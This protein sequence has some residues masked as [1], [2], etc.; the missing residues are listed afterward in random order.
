MCV[1]V[2]DRGRKEKYRETK[3]ERFMWGEGRNTSHRLVRASLQLINRFSLVGL[4]EIWNF[5]ERQE[6]PSQRALIRAVNG[7]RWWGSYKYWIR[8]FAI[9]YGR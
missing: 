3:H 7:N 9:K 5:K 8:D 2:C 6:K 1:C 4:R